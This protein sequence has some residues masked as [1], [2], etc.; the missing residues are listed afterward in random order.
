MSPMDSLYPCKY[1]NNA[2]EKENSLIVSKQHGIPVCVLGLYLSRTY[3]IVPASS[4]H[5]Q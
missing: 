5:L 1:V 2:R 4:D 3:G